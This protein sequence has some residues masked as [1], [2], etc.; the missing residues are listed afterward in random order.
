MAP[1]DLYAIAAG[2][3][4]VLMLGGCACLQPAYPP[5]SALLPTETIRDEG[6]SYHYLPA[7]EPVTATADLVAE[8]DR[9]LTAADFPTRRGRTWTTSAMYRETPPEIE[10]YRDDGVISLCMESVALWA[11]CQ[12][13]DV[14]AGTVHQIGDYLAPDEWT[15]ESNPG[16]G[17]PGM[18]EPTVAAL[19]TYV[20][21]D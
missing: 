16:R 17:L 12:F 20:D 18:L 9:E 8:L 5:E 7:D 10:R 1:G 19:E 13:R 3:R 14:A 21:T 4:A 15:P 2:A 6:V 11:V